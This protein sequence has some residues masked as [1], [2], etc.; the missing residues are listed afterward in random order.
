[1]NRDMRRRLK[2]DQAAGI[3]DFIDRVTGPGIILTPI[4]IY[5]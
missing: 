4:A 3:D 5:R 2:L 1:M